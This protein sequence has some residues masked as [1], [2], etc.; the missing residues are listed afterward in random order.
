MQCLGNAPRVVLGGRGWHSYQREKTGIKG[1]P[2]QRRSSWFFVSL[3]ETFGHREEDVT[4]TKGTRERTASCGCGNL[5][6]TTRGEHCE[7]HACS[8]LSCQRESGSAFTY[9]AHYPKAAVSIAGERRVWRRHVDSGRW[10][11]TGFCPTCGGAVFSRSEI[12]PETIGVAVGCYADP[13]F[14][15]PERV[16]WN[17]RRHHWLQFPEGTELLETEP[18]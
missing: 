15:K 9:C 14:A 18:D 10:M 6:V 2:R 5:T 1:T 8:C 11:E 12:S 7:V 17:S 13:D 16:Y 3:G 4:E